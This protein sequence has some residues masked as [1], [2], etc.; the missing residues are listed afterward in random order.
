MPRS[1]ESS[2]LSL[3]GLGSELLDDPH[4]DAAAVGESLRNIARANRWFGG[5]RAVR[6]G[7]ARVL[8]GVPRGTSLTLLDLGTGLG[9][10]PLATVRWARRRGVRLLPL[11][12]ERSRVAAALAHAAG[13]ATVVA[14]LGRLPLRDRSADIVLLSQV[15]HHFAPDSVVTLFRVCDRLARHAVIVADLRR[16]PLAGAGFAI[17]ARLLRFDPL[18]RADGHTSI[19]RGFTERELAA[20]LA[21]AG[22]AAA[23]RRVAPWRLVAAWRTAH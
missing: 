7:L 21:R 17:G 14:D 3:S 1:A 19:R 20:L 22:L 6:W 18:T 4:A 11:G 2:P 15:A 10:L 12:L 13:I 5:T 9:D 16:S 23:V 8:A